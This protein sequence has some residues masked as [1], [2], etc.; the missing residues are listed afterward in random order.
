[1]LSNEKQKQFARLAV[2]IGVN[3]QKGQILIINSPIE[4]G[5][6]ARI[7][8][9]T[10]FEAGAKDVF[11]YWKDEKLSKIRYQ[12]ADTETLV[13]IPEWM[14]AQKLYGVTQKAAHISITSDDPDI[15]EGIDAG[16]IKAY[17]T[18]SSKKFI[19][20]RKATMSN[21]VRWC[22]VPVPSVNWAKKIFPNCS[23]EQ[24]VDKLWDAI[25]VTMRLNEKDPVK[26][27]KEHNE[28]LEH[29][30]KFL[31]EH[32]F[33]YIRMTNSKGTDL[34]VGLAEG[35]I[36]TGAGEKALDGINFTANMPTE[37]VFTAPHK[38][39][40]NGIVKSALPLVENGTVI[41]D[42]FIEFKDGR[43]CNFGAAKGYETLKNL[44]ETDEGSHYLGEIALIGKHSPI[45]ELGIL[46]YNT[47]FDENASC[48]LALGKGYPS[49]VKNGDKLTVEQLDK[50]GVNDSIE[51]CDFMVGT[52]D[53]HVEGIG[54]DGKVVALFEDGEWV[55]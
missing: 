23:D 46:F 16:K 50:L 49:T 26:A 33:E 34:K 17:S 55:I 2:E 9:E 47:L 41:D 40:V 20:F 13:D 15:F 44:V 10:A 7:I 22:I 45:S 52:K 38:Y 35:H 42:F 51:H 53:L 21:A 54:Y 48:H 37:E 12:H 39:K 29:R 36:W 11:V 27:W 32:N 14:V 28:K 4:C 30:A 18:E 24:A 8:A 19:E 3:L 6:F 5:E 31:N 1:M 25:A 43:V